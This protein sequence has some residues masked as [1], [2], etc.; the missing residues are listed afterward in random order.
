M[1]SYI[2]S[3]IHAISVKM[4]SMNHVKGP[5]W[6]I[7]QIQSDNDSAFPVSI[8]PDTDTQPWI[9]L[10]KPKAISL[11]NSVLEVDITVT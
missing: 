9:S 6:K 11:C 3:M 10:R 8:S 7:S 1:M 4:H 2:L 5:E